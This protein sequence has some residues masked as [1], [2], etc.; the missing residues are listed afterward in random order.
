MRYAEL[1]GN[2][3]KAVLPAELADV[4]EILPP[5]A[6]EIPL[7]STVHD[8]MIYEDGLFREETADEIAIQITPVPEPPKPSIYPEMVSTEVRVIDGISYFVRKFGLNSVVY[9]ELL[10]LLPTSKVTHVLNPD[11]TEN[12]DLLTTTVIP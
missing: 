11:G 6:V 8:G 1:N 3:V 2:K 10:V 12:I 7:D 4:Y 5:Y 9:E